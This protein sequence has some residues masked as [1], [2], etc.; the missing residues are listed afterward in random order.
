MG[1]S[2]QVTQPT[3]KQKMIAARTR[4]VL[5]QPFFGALALRLKLYEDPGCGTA[6]VDGVTLGYDPKFIEALTPDQVTALVAHEVLHCACGHPWRRDNREPLRWNVA[7]DL[8]INPV[9]VGAGF[10]LP[11]GGLL[12][13]KFAGKSAEWIF[14]RVPPTRVITLRLARQG[15]PKGQGK[16]Q[17]PQ[18]A[19]GPGTEPGEPQG[20]GKQLLGEV[21]D[22]PHSKGGAEAPSASDAPTEADWQAAVQQAAQAAQARGNLPA[23]LARFAGETVEPRVDWRS[24]LRRFIQQCAKTD[25]SWTRPS[26]RYLARGLYLPDLHS[27]EMGAIAVAVDTSGSID[28][29]MLQQFA[30][31]MRAIA[32]EARPCRIEVL[33]C[34]AAVAARETFERDEPLELHPAGGGGTDFRPV[35]NAIEQQEEQPV[36][37]IYLTDLFGSFPETPPELPTLW[38]TT[39]RG[40]DVPFGELVVIQ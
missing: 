19:G 8:A 22:A 21:R 15:S 34:D 6:W 38:A 17:G 36:C 7:C 26:R 18:G 10:T 33:Y 4:L 27:E 32:D 24:V 35:F 14:D 16:G 28:N 25:F 9:L 11:P 37:V 31:E 40:K 2:K 12:D 1:T 13:P 29:V 30:A 3:A 5:E 39:T 23:N 20:P